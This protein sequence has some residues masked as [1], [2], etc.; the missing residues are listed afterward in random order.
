[1]KIT[2]Y[3]HLYRQVQYPMEHGYRWEPILLPP[4]VYLTI[5]T[6]N[7]TKFLTVYSRLHVNKEVRI[8]PDYASTFSDLEIIKDLS[9]KIN[10]M[11][12]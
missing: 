10:G 8:N 2:M 3:H 5:T 6:D 7:D 9:G 12:L 4:W 11:F 1:M